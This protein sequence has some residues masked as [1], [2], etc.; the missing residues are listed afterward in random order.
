MS[1]KTDQTSP[2]HQNNLFLAIDLASIIGWGMVGIFI[3]LS[4]IRSPFVIISLR[5]II[6][7]F[8]LMITLLFQGKTKQVFRNFLSEKI[9]IVLSLILFLTYFFGTMAF[10]LAPIGEV[11]LL[12]SISPFFVIL[13]K[14]ISGNAISKN[15]YVGTLIAVLGVVVIMYPNLSAQSHVSSSS[16]LGHV[17]AL[18]A[19]LL[20]AF[21]VVIS[22][23]QDL[24]QKKINS[25]S[26][27]LGTCLFGVLLFLLTLL[28]NT[29]AFSFESSSGINW[30]SIFALGVFSTAVPTLGF[31][32]ASKKLLPLLLSNLLLLEPVFAIV[33]AYLFLSETPNIYIYPGI[34][35]I[36][37]GLLRVS[38]K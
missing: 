36:F 18:G 33:F 7:F 2:N 38:A 9:T 16:L 8:I 20:F 11:T 1:T 27:T 26:I 25:L 15:E 37:I 32:Y 17:F 21:F 5:F 34:I 6:T 4:S 3:R 14:K 28:F 10:M 31:A 19:S 22:S 24:L 30:L 13:F 29:G 23:S 12:I 35:L